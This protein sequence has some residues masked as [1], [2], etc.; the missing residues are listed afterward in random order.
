MTAGAVGKGRRS[1]LCRPIQRVVLL[2]GLAAAGVF[3]IA[4]SGDDTNAGGAP[5]DVAYADDVPAAPVAGDTETSCSG[6]DPGVSEPPGAQ[7]GG[8][9]AGGGSPFAAA[10]ARQV[11]GPNTT[12]TS[13]PSAPVSVVVVPPPNPDTPAAAS[14]IEGVGTPAPTYD[15]S[16]D[17]SIP[18]SPAS[19][20]SEVGSAP[21]AAEQCVGGL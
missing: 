15:L 13:T 2:I 5:N 9:I 8:T 14:L 7:P 11:P 1:A 10:G 6:A 4:C 18:P 16:G 12:V 3:P 20:S 19:P 21:T 17:P